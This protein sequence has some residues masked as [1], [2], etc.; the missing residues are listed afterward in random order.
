MLVR[1]M[2]LRPWNPK[3]RAGTWCEVAQP[4]KKG[5]RRLKSPDKGLKG[6]VSIW[7]KE[8]PYKMVNETHLQGHSPHF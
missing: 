2:R 8:I 7:D 4:N 6:P 1:C 3:S 5:Q